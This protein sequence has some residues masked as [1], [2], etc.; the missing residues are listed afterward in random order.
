MPG[1]SDTGEGGGTLI[2]PVLGG[3]L[4]GAALQL[5][6]PQLWALPVYI[7]LFA[8]GLALLVAARRARRLAWP[9]ALAGALLAG[10][11]GC[12]WR[13]QVFA[14]Q[15]LDPALQGRDLVVTGVVDAMP[16]RSDT[17]LRFRLAVESARLDGAPV[18]L[19]PLIQLGWWG[20][21][22][23]GELTRQSAD[24]RAGERWRMTVRL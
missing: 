4:A 7:G 13:A 17:G 12:G 16:Q 15:A 3:A 14:G 23:G 22:G 20:G 11:A 9:L 1:V 5:Q 10:G 8:L 21:A 19:P 2:V 18:R 24:L 6:Q